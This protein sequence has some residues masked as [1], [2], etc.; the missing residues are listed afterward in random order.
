MTTVYRKTPMARREAWSYC[1]RCLAVMLCCVLVSTLTVRTSPRA[2]AT[3][4]VAGD[5]GVLGAA[6]GLLSLIGSGVDVNMSADQI[7]EDGHL[8][9]RRVSMM[10]RMGYRYGAQLHDYLTGDMV[11]AADRAAWAEIVAQFESEGGIMPGQSFTLPSHL[12][13]TVRQWAGSNLEFVDRALKFDDKVL[14]SE[15]GVFVMSSVDMAQAQIIYQTS[16]QTIYSAPVANL[17]TLI[18]FPAFDRT[19]DLV[20]ETRLT[21]YGIKVIYTY[22]A[23]TETSTSRSISMR[24]NIR[25]GK[26]NSGSGACMVIGGGGGAL[27]DDDL[28]EALQAR[29]GLFYDADSNRIYAI[30]GFTDNFSKATYR[31]LYYYTPT[32]ENAPATLTTTFTPTGSLSIPTEKDRVINVPSDL[33]TVDVGGL[34]VPDIDSLTGQDLL[35]GEIPDDPAVPSAAPG[36]TAGEITGAITDALPITG[37]IA[38]DQVVEEVTSD[39]DSLG[40]VFISKFPFSIPWDVVKAISLLAAPPVTPHWEIDFFSSLEGFNGFHARGD[41]TIVVDFERFEFLGQLCRWTSTLF[42]VYALALGTK[43]LIWTA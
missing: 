11:D 32:A 26:L 10:D 18:S 36:I 6:A 13:E 2:E 23:P 37:A 40:A 3:A 38:G 30:E 24:I 35:A 22:K 5:A 9:P 28:N 16:S 34:S 21:S 20:A 19:K 27:D 15:D 43:R 25:D 14:W 7:G 33:P 1:R 12:A 41:T 42:F 8:I 31:S 29:G 4:A 17:G 39:P